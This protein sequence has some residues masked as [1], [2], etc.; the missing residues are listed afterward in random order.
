MNNNMNEM[1]KTLPELLHMLRIVELNFKKPKPS[2]IMMVQKGKGKGK[3]QLQGI[4]KMDLKSK[5][6]P[7]PFT[8]A[9]KP[10]RKM[11]KKGNFFHYGEI[12][13]WKKNYKAYLKEMKKNKGG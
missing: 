4:K 13:H 3:A 9:L 5:Q 1:E 8:F 12:G 10:I 7:K 6:K 2:S 11:A